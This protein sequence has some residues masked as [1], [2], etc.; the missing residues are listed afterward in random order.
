MH[1]LAVGWFYKVPQ[2][3]DTSL[4]GLLEYFFFED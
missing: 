2:K 4:L 3:A 1:S